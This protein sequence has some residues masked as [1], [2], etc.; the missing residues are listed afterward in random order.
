[1]K[2]ASC[3]KLSTQ[4]WILVR[5]P[6][7]ERPRAC[8]LFFHGTG[9]MLMK[10]ILVPLNDD[11]MR[12]LLAQRDKHSVKVFVYNGEQGFAATTAAW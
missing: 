2:R 9:R 12:V 5:S 4:A 6:P 3:P 11:A 1:M 8:R 7:R 10:A